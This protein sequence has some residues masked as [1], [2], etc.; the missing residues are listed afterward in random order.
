MATSTELPSTMKAQHLDAY[1]TPYVLRDG[2][3]VPKPTHPWDVLI[4]VDAASYC[5]TDYVLAAGEMPGNPEKFPLVGSHE[6]AGTV[7]ALPPS[8]AQT[9]IKLGM[10]VGVGSRAYHPCGTCAE[11]LK[12]SSPDSD[13]R[14]YSVFCPAIKS[15]GIGIDGGWQEYAL[16]D[17][18]QVAP[19]PDSLSVVEAAPLMCAGVTIYNAIKKAGLRRGQRLG[20]IGAGGGLGHLGLQYAT[21]MGLRVYGV[22]NTDRA[23]ELARGLP[24]IEG[25]R[26]IDARREP[27]ADI[28]AQVGA[29]DGA[30]H[31]G[32]KGLDA[33]II[34]PESQAAFQYG[35]DLLKNH[36]KCV[37]VSFPQRGFHVSAHDLV[38]RDIAVVG[39]LVGSNKVLREMVDFTAKHGIKAVIKTYPLEQLNQLVE[40]YKSGQGGKFVI[41]FHYKA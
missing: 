11:C 2:L 41:D 38:F 10:R 9:A 8:P 30:V 37:V 16:V 23:L 17:A 4:R 5:H 22:D 14:G 3:P 29:E 6:Y 31:R 34:L 21:K 36:G 12:N 24:N 1:N 26:I 7:V 18:R 15:N 20:I 33:V 25:V 19:I 13:P 32:E 28:V 35:V 39:S 40:D 27:A